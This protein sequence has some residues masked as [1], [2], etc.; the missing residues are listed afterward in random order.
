[1][2]LD[3]ILQPEPGDWGKSET[4]IALHC[5]TLRFLRFMRHY[6]GTTITA[7]VDAAIR[8]KLV[9]DGLASE[10]RFLPPEVG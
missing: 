9:R 5:V 2:E 1:M 4:T 6:R 8:E 3:H 10:A 7:F